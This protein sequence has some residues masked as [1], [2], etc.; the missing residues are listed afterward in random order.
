[1]MVLSDGATAIAPGFLAR[2]GL[3]WLGLPVFD[4]DWDR[5]GP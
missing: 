2:I 3:G 5:R 1:M 4:F